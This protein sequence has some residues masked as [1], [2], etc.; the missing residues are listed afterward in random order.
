VVRAGY[1][2]REFASIVINCFDKERE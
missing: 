2:Y 1:A